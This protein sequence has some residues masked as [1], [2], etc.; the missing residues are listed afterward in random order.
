MQL[1]KRVNLVNGQTQD[2]IQEQPLLAAET[3]LKAL[4]FNYGIRAFRDNKPCLPALDKKFLDNIILEIKPEE[5]S[6][7][8]LDQWCRGWMIA[9]HFR[10]TN[11]SF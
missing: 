6:K 9:S 11:Y 10:N 8:Y 2:Q 7:Q 5:L 3:T 4:S 1:I